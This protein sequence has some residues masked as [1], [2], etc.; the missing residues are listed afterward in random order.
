MTVD[1]SN[2][3]QMPRIGETIADKYQLT[4]MMGAG[5]MGAVYKALQ[6]NLGREIA[7]KL[8]LPGI[9]HR[10][11]ARKRF[12]R[13]AKVAAALHHPNAVEIYDFGEDA[14]GRL[15]LAMEL[16]HGTTLRSYVDEHLPAFPWTR[17]VPIMA[18]VAD[19][20]VSAHKL[21]LVHRDL[22]PENVFLEH[23]RRMTREGIVVGT[24]DYISPEQASG[25]ENVGP[26]TDVYA[27][28]CMLYE[29]ATC[30]VPFRGDELQMLTQHLFKSP[31]P[32]SETAPEG[33]K[34]PRQ[35]EE[36][37]LRTL[38]KKP[39]DRPDAFEVTHKLNAIYESLDRRERARDE[40]YLLGREARMIPTVQ[41][42]GTPTAQSPFAIGAAAASGGLLAST[43]TSPQ[44]ALV[45]TQQDDVLLALSANGLVGYIVSAAQTVD[46]ADVIFAPGADEAQLRELIRYEVPVLTD[47]DAADMKRIAALLTIGVDEVLPRPV[48]ANDLAR[49]IQRALRKHKRSKKKKKG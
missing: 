18:Q 34:V 47:T 5:G 12:E 26:P 20:L 16:L 35:L 31:V 17:G 42:R 10:K 19:V 48:L 29:I 21:N 30:Y 6:T 9:G 46:G 7:V 45:G 33:R 24:P 13:E 32:P 15:F 37:I 36:L 22:K 44:I 41:P 28:G 14:H 43:S 2:H 25:D 1:L 40:G 11:G 49:R 4:E 8:L 3:E 39:H 27:L 23:T 38:A